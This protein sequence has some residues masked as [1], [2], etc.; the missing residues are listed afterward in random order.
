[1]QEDLDLIGACR[2]VADWGNAAASATSPVLARAIEQV[3]NVLSKAK[4]FEYMKVH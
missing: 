3:S 1:M 2:L 4:V